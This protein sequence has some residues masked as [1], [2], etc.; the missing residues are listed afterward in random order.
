MVIYVFF[1]E[2]TTIWWH[3]TRLVALQQCGAPAHR[4]ALVKLSNQLRIQTPLEFWLPRQRRQT[5]TQLSIRYGRPCRNNTDTSRQYW[6]TET[7]A[8]SVP[9][10]SWPDQY[11]YGYWPVVYKTEREFMWRAIISSAS[12]ELA[13]S[14]QCIW[15]VLCN[16]SLK[17][18]LIYCKNAREMSIFSTL[19]FCQVERQRNE[20]QVIGF[21]QIICADHTWL[22]RWKV[23][24]I[25]Q[26]K[27]KI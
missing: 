25:G 11:Q 9:V 16:V 2:M 15:F 6:W 3:L 12:R 17:Y 1:C 24:K 10:Q 27:P 13:H 22:E 20:G 19:L 26:Q 14:E 7:A 4:I 8:D 5:T 21:I 23:V 18:S